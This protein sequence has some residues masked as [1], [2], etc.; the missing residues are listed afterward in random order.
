MTSR[1]R[2]PGLLFTE[3]EQPDW[4][5]AAAEDRLIAQV[6]FNRPLDTA[7]HYLVPDSLR[8]LIEPGQRVQVPFGRG[9]QATL[10]YCVGLVTEGFSGKR[11]KSI[12]E[13]C[14][15]TPLISAGM[16]ELTRWISERYLCSWGQVLDSVIPAGV[17]RQAGTREIVCFELAADGVATGRKLPPKQ[18]AILDLLAASDAPLTVE[19]LTQAAACGTSPIETL[20]KKGLIVPLRRRSSVGEARSL[21]VEKQ[22]DLKLNE[23]Q[24]AALDCLVDLLRNQRHETV[25]MH[26]ITGSGKTEV[27]I[28]AIREVISYG[29]QAI[30]LVP[31]ISLT[32]QTIRRFRARFDSVAVLHSHLSDAD[33]HWHWQEIAQGRVQVIVGARSAIFAPTP[34]LGLIVIDEEHETTFKQQTTPRYHARDVAR[35]RA[36]RENIPL[37]LGSATPTLESLVRTQ[38][39]TDILLPMLQRVER[40]P[41]PR[42]TLVDI[43]NDPLISKRHAIGRALGQGITRALES[44][45][46]VILFLNLRGFSP[47]M[48][49]PKCGGIRC[50]DCDLTLTWHRDREV[51]LCHSCEHQT[52]VP[53]RCPTCAQPGMRFLGTGT[54]K[55]EAEVKIKFPDARVIRMDSDS[56]RKPGSHD[57]A[58]DAFRQGKIDILLGTQMI[59]KGLDFPNVTMVGVVDADTL[60]HQPDLR[61]AERTFQLIA[62][63]A[64]RTGRGD[65]E[66]RVFVQTM[67]PDDPVI[68]FAA[69]HDYNGFAKRELEIRRQIQAP[70]FTMM[71]RVILRSLDDRIVQQ[72]TR[73]I[74]DLVRGIAAE[75]GSAVRILGP[76][77]APVTRLRKYFRYHFQMTAPQLEL[78][79]ALWTAAVPRLNI[80]P[81]VEL[82]IDIDPLDLR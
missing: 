57:A 36:R 18:Q 5:V 47:V 59:A 9:D 46:Q 42:V 27:Y 49:C 54:Q 6:V 60:L 13:I 3:I 17:K 11:L 21:D 45:G 70:P 71:A 43:R 19:E 2:Q 41:L 37:I 4:E 72:E 66:G 64:G 15:R 32:P 20:R 22:A 50:P 73:R 65:R 51:L 67:N 1:P 30:V 61:A 69:Q 78:I 25:L 14:D 7:Y 29:R 12:S 74:T 77:P 79:Q 16:L 10:G 33:R 26:G 39:G 34:H 23:E 75:S 62:Q 52:T 35:E 55:L 31:E 8:E 76:A 56:M 53:E 80:H 28:Q 38:A 82:T 40:R 58:L 48:W 44:Q 81:E 63:V 68:Q 24:Q